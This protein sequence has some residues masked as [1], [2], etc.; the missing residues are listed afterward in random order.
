[1]T[2]QV[3]FITLS[4]LATPVLADIQTPTSFRYAGGAPDFLTSGKVYAVWNARDPQK[5]LAPGLKVLFFGQPKG[6]RA[7]A[8]EGPTAGKGNPRLVRAEELTGVKP[9]PD[10]WSWSPS[11]DT[12]DCESGARKKVGDSFV[13]I[14]RHKA[15]GGIG[16]FTYTGKD[17]GGQDPFFQ[18]FEA[19][20]Q[21]GQG[22]NAFIN[23]TFLVFRFGW[24]GEGR[25]M[26]WAGERDSAD[27]ALVFRSIQSVVRA[28][29]TPGSSREPVQA[30]QQMTFTVINRACFR[31]IG[32]PG[33]LCQVQY[34]MNTAVYR[35]GVAN[36]D[37]EKWFKDAT[38]WFDPAQGGMPIVHGPVPANGQTARDAASRV[39]LYKSLGE[40]SQ[41]GEFDDKAFAVSV[42]FAQLKNALRVAT[43]AR[44]KRPVPEIG[45][46]ALSAEF[47]ARW[48][49]PNEWALLSIDFSQEVH[50]PSRDRRA[51]IGGNLTELSV[52]Q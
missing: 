47:G 23:G 25:I 41:H 16:L 44:L 3:C 31:A 50:N 13:L 30:K 35:A 11:S 37:S 52:G 48:S 7:G 40:P 51:F 20:G 5:V 6:C 2:R 24:Q 27:P 28:V 15:K 29:V 38:V 14:S 21:N 45:D 36:W 17:A 1:M 32:G 39:D 12:P 33:K 26:P 49:D 8:T 18:Q 43:A 19:G 9:D 22:A 34:L 10:A 46:A 4:L 42:T